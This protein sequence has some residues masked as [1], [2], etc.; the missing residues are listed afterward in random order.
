MPAPVDRIQVVPYALAQAQDGVPPNW[1]AGIENL[2]AYLEDF[3]AA[4]DRS[5][6][7]EM[8]QKAQWNAKVTP[9]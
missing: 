7:K 8:L 4:P 6:V 5:V 9:K 1:D 3:P 2:R